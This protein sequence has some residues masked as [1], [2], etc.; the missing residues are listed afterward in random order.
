[1][2]LSEKENL[3]CLAIGQILHLKVCL[4]GKRDFKCAMNFIFSKGICLNLWCQKKSSL[5]LSR[6]MKEGGKQ[7]VKTEAVNRTDESELKPALL[8]KEISIQYSLRKVS[9]CKEG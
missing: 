8:M 3:C 7:S 9:L 2:K 5:G 4:D 1:M 6:L